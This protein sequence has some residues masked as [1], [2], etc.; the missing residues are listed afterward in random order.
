[1]LKIELDR[2]IKQIMKNNKWWTYICEANQ[3]NQNT[4]R[5]SLPGGDAQSN[6]QW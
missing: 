1:M 5:E 6:I 3:L 4:V 2:I